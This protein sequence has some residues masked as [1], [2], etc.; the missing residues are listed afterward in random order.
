ALDQF[1]DLRDLK[2]VVNTHY[3]PEQIEAHLKGRDVDVLR[4]KGEILETGGGL[5]NALPKLGSGPVF[6]MNTDAVW[7]AANPVSTLLDAWD[8][9]PQTEALLLLVPQ[10]RAWAHKGTGDFSVTPDGCLSR[11]GPYTY[12]GVQILRTDRLADISERS[13]SLNLIWSDMIAAG[14]A[15]G[16]I[17]D[18]HW[19][20]VGAPEGI[21]IAEDMLR[22]HDV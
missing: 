17:F 15:K 14:T 18:G 16:V 1:R 10:D 3:F 9:D 7:A 13:F 12:T 11:G 21:T 19:C 8:Q 4:E 5:K 2:L 20:D 6:T 22:R